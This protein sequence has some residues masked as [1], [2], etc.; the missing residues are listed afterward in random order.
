MMTLSNGNIFRVTGHCAGISRTP[1]NSQHKGQWRG[2]LTFSLICVWINGW[3]NNR[4]AGD[5]RRYRAHYYVIECMYTCGTFTHTFR[6]TLTGTGEMC[7]IVP[8]P[9]TLSWM[10]FRF[11]LHLYDLCRSVL[12]YYKYIIF[13]NWRQSVPCYASF[14]F[15]T[16]VWIYTILVFSTLF[17]SVAL[18]STWDQL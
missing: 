7:M 10:M 9:V 15:V 8:V 16:P 1:V 2:A 4:E 12:F 11:V 14:F 17:V 13:Q 3:V 6:D 5:L 18:I